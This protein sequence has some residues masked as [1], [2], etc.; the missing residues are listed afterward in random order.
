MGM[1]KELV[2]RLFETHAFKVAPEEEPF[3]YTSGKLG[4]YFI[5]VDYLYG[6]KE[7][8]AELLK[9]IDN[10]LENTPKEEIPYELC[11]KIMEHYDNNE[12]L[13]NTDIRN[14]TELLLISS[15]AFLNR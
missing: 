4:S 7:D 9:F 12:I 2:S 14:S 6:S 8:S 3:W 10:L 11:E 1:D 15:T 13:I 5:N